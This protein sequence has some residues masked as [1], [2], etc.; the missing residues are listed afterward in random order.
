MR[1][2]AFLQLLTLFSL[3]PVSPCTK[4]SVLPLDVAD[5]WLEGTVYYFT[6]HP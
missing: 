5:Y 6:D 4:P 3:G 1:R 2:R